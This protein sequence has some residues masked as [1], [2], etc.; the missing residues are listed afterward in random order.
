MQMMERKRM[1]AM[2]KQHIQSKDRIEELQEKIG[3][4]SGNKAK[5][6]QQM[7]ERLAA[8]REEKARRSSERHGNIVGK[9]HYNTEEHMRSLN[10]KYDRAQQNHED[11][12]NRVR[13]RLQQTSLI[14]VS[15]MFATLRSEGRLFTV[16]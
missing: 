14:Q 2:V 4:K 13:Q 9:G 10:E 11:A 16:P 7:Q 1:Q 15:M 8:K 12:T 6:I 3:D 5:L